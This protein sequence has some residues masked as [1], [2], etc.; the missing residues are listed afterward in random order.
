VTLTRAAHWDDGPR[1]G[2]SFPQA[3]AEDPLLSSDNGHPGHNALPNSS[4]FGPV[5]LEGCFTP[6]PPPPQQPQG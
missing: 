4:L 2:L 5:S 6:P 1:D 3:G